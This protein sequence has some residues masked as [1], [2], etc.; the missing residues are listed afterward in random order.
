MI[1]GGGG[2]PRKERRKD[3]CRKMTTRLAAIES[4]SGERYY[5]IGM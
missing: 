2:G 1:G 4:L 5:A 3:A